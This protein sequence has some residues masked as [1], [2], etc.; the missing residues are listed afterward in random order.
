MTV[1][2]SVEKDYARD[3]ASDGNEYL[4]KHLL[5]EEIRKS[6][7]DKLPYI[8][9]K[10]K[11]KLFEQGMSKLLRQGFESDIIWVG[12]DKDFN[13]NFTSGAWDKGCSTTMFYKWYILDL[14]KIVAVKKPR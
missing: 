13:P 10:Q 4:C 11:E 9:D 12:D 14:Y 1:A 3:R 6:D 7:F 2:V 5:R 8:I